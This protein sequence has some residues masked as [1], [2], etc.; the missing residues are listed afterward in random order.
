MSEDTAWA[1]LILLEEF[2][3]EV[4]GSVFYLNMKSDCTEHFSLGF[5]NLNDPHSVEFSS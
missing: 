4:I 5:T 3:C 1:W 2:Y